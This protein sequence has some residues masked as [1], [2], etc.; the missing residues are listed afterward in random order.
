MLIVIL[1]HATAIEKS[2][3]QKLSAELRNRIWEFA[4]I[5]EDPIRVVSPPAGLRATAVDC[6][7]PAITRTCAQIRNEALGMF[8]AKNTFLLKISC[9]DDLNLAVGNSWKP[10]L[11]HN[12]EH[13]ISKACRWLTNSPRYHHDAISSL[14]LVKHL[15]YFALHE[16]DVLYPFKDSL[17][18][19]AKALKSCGYD[20]ARLKI[21]VKVIVVMDFFTD[22]DE[23]AIMRAF[24]SL[25]MDVSLQI[26]KLSDI[27]K[28]IEE[29]TAASELTPEQAEQARVIASWER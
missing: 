29:K 24:E 22:K 16:G 13:H 8:Y 14:V 12:V 10:D 6:I 28:A 26:N 7:Q 27:K 18:G 1:A 25:G 17:F 11:E 15:E 3:F 2:P 19:L 21:L 4:I 20:G 23:A 5:E 9:G